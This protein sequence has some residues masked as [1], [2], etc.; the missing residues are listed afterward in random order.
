MDYPGGP[1][2]GIN[3]ILKNS[4]KGLKMLCSMLKRDLRLF[5]RCLLPALC[6]TLVFA[7]VCAGAAFAALKGAEEL[8]TP[9]KAA[10]V[11]EEDSVLSR[12]LIR[13]AAGTDYISGLMDISRCGM[14]EAM[15]G[16]R[17]GDYAAVIVLPEGFTGDISRGEY[18]RGRI[19]L[20]PAA[21]SHS[22]VVGS[23]AAF[24][25]L[26]LAAGQYGV[27]SGEELIR[28]YGLGSDFHSAF[29]TQV[30][31]QLLRE[32]M[33]A[34]S[35][36]FDMEVTDYAGSSMSSASYYAVSW[37][38][39]V[40]FLCSIFFTRLYTAD[41]T[42]SMLCR[43]RAAGVR[44]RAFVW[45]KLLWPA[46]FRLLLL[47]PAAA[48]LSRFLPVTPGAGALLSCLAAVLA[49]SVT[50]AAL[51]MGTGSGAAV[52][53]I[54]AA[55]GLFLCG[56]IVPRQMLPDGVL[57]LGSLTPFGG[58]QALLAPLF[59][60]GLAPWPAAA[61]L[62]H[63]LAGLLWISRRLSGLRVGGEEA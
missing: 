15:E 55:A 57:L 47:V 60:G 8:Y 19:L 49:V 38:T 32:A 58:V 27:F 34:E 22:Q 9:V 5:L 23:A 14:D 52:N 40:L 33:G 4:P 63:T 13:V 29:L 50:G 1:A 21:A 3:G 56:G 45:G 31:T 18:S 26:L 24:G 6:L 30:N 61:A 35:A 39:L 7:L 59:G 62:I 48:L 41:L 53:G 2:A 44:D 25:E 12:M 42:R 20:S 54:A 43:L 11:D 17:A 37:L 10:V 28:E 36:Y 51:G 16:L 46:L